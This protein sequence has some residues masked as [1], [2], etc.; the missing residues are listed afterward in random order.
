MYPCFARTRLLSIL[1]ASTVPGP[2]EIDREGEEQFAVANIIN[3][4]N[5]PRTGVLQYLVEW[6]G[7]EGTDEHTIWEPREN[8]TSAMEKIDK[9][10]RR[11]PDKPSNDIRKRR[12]TLA[13]R[14]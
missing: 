7:Y 12:Q 1:D 2:V 9:F 11:Y 4:T 8:V 3:S 14:G 5:N 10:H 13:K 6:L